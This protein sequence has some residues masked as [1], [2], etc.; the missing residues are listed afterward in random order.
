MLT[1]LTSSQVSGEEARA[2]LP[3]GES[4]CR[5]VWSWTL[6]LPRTV[7]GELSSEVAAR[8]WSVAEAG[9]RC[10]G[11]STKRSVA[12]AAVARQGPCLGPVRAAS[13][14]G[15]TGVLDCHTRD[16]YADWP[17]KAGAV[18]GNLRLVAA[19]HPQD[20]ALHALLG[21]LSAK[22]PISSMWADHRVGRPGAEGALGWHCLTSCNVTGRSAGSGEPPSHI[23]DQPTAGQRR[24]ASRGRTAPKLGATGRHMWTTG[25][26]F[27][28]WA[29]TPR[30]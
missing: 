17:S 10:C 14:H 3:A 21:D 12:A 7:P 22:S 8:C 27:S 4:S 28:S 6:R 15:Q 20:T 24:A 19:Q 29:G 1:L 2:R 16:L 5:G 13:Q 18:V 9:A 26:A 11:W 30:R 25:A 23:P